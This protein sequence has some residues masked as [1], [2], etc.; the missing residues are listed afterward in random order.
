MIPVWFSTPLRSLWTDLLKYFH[1]TEEDEAEEIIASA[2]YLARVRER[3]RPR[4]TDALM[5]YTRQTAIL[6][7]VPLSE[8]ATVV[9]A[10]FQYLIPKSKRAL[11]LLAVLDDAELLL[12][13]IERMHEFCDGLRRRTDRARRRETNSD[14]AQRMERIFYVDVTTLASNRRS[15]RGITPDMCEDPKTLLHALELADRYGLSRLA[16]CWHLAHA[17]FSRGFQMAPVAGYLSVHGSQAIG[18]LTD[19]LQEPRLNEPELGNLLKHPELV[20]KATSKLTEI[21]SEWEASS[22]SG[23]FHRFVEQAL[24]T[25]MPSAESNRPDSTTSSA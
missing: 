21:L 16:D 11:R 8:A 17:V 13:D 4:I 9:V 24:I 12:E 6:H 15:L 20:P 7:D 23:E 18:D 14:R 2:L 19:L 22:R 5:R 10:Y 3:N 25:P 1:L